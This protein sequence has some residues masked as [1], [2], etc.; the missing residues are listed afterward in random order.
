MGM[1]GHAPTSSAWN[2]CKLGYTQSSRVSVRR[3]I[4]PLLPEGILDL[5]D[6][7]EH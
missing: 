1:N 7:A 5:I 2:G 6:L 3:R 4:N